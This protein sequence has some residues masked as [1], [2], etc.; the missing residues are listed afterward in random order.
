MVRNLLDAGLR[1][2]KHGVPRVSRKTGGQS[3]GV[4]QDDESPIRRHRDA[5]SLGVGSKGGDGGG[6]RS[7]GPRRSGGA[8]CPGGPGSTGRARNPGQSCRAVRPRRLQWDPQRRSAARTIRSGGTLHGGGCQRSLHL[9]VQEELVLCGGLP[10]IL[11]TLSLAASTSLT[12]AGGPLRPG[13][14]PRIY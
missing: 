9:R 2:G 12:V 5:A 13:R 4:G 1:H 10:S 8:G 11:R 14:V 6:I 7:G 3:L